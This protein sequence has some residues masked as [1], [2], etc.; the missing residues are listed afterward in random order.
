[1]ENTMVQKGRPVVLYSGLKGRRLVDLPEGTTET[2]MCFTDIVPQIQ[3]RINGD[4]SKQHLLEPV[5]ADAM[6]PAV[7]LSIRTIKHE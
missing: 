3:V 7:D 1:M 5:G 6:R 2:R 4:W